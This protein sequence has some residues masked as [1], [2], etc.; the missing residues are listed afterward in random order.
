MPKELPA[1]VM[2]IYLQEIMKQMNQAPP[3]CYDS[4]GP[5][6]EK[7]PEPSWIEAYRYLLTVDR[8]T[9]IRTF[10]GMVEGYEESPRW[11]YSSAA[12]ATMQCVKMEEDK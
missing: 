12:V 4:P 1:A 11:L 9:L 8:K 7:E 5:V 2:P 3:I 10:V 6:R